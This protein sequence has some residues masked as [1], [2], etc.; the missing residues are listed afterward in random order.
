MIRSS[1]HSS[2]FSALVFSAA[3]L[4]GLSGCEGFSQLQD[5]ELARGEA[6][7][8]STELGATLGVAMADGR[9]YSAASA[10][11]Q[12]AWTDGAPMTQDGCAAVSVVDALGTDGTGAVRY[13][14]GACSGRQGAVVVAQEVVREGG[15]PTGSQGGQGASGPEMPPGSEADSGL[16]QDLEASSASFQVI[17]SGYENG[18]LRI[19]GHLDMSEDGDV[20]TVE[21]QVTLG[22]LDYIGE[23]D[24]A[25]TW[26]ET[27]D[28]LGTR[29]SVSGTFVSAT[30]VEWS[31]VADNVVFQPGCLDG[32][33]GQLSLIHDSP[34]GRVTAITTFDEV[35][36]GCANLEVD[37]EDYGRTC[38]GDGSMI[39]GAITGMLQ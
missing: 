19:S 32:V 34:V 7:F 4:S 31:L 27:A 24:A 28:A 37:G 22:A 18:A 23:V 17:Y 3:V 6:R 14:F 36:D 20:G 8:V 30:G 29:T 35:C 21:A 11:A 13:D 9:E 15:A 38:F 2:S 16:L 26:V 25:G 5:L 39:G 12:I 10:E 1:L 33:G